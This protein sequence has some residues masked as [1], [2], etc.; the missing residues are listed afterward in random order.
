MRKRS[1]IPPYRDPAPHNDAPRPID[2]RRTEGAAVRARR[3]P[4]R[5]L[6]PDDRDR[7]AETDRGRSPID[8]LLAG[9]GPDE[10]GTR[11]CRPDPAP[12]EAR[13]RPRRATRPP[14]LLGSELEPGIIWDSGLPPPTPPIGR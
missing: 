7:R 9:G 6:H 14:H 1:E 5:P 2:Q 13:H 12:R 8:V 4:S 11:G 10:R 3:R